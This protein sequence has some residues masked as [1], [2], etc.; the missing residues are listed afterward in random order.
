MRAGLKSIAIGVMSGALALAATMPGFASERCAIPEREFIRPNADDAAR[1]LD[2]F[3]ARMEGMAAA[4]IVESA[5]DRQLVSDLLGSGF[6]AMDADKIPLGSYQCR[7]IK[8][9]GISDLI[10]YSWF[11]CEIGNE[12]NTI[13][14]RKVTGSQNFM[15]FMVPSGESLF[16]RG[17]SHYGYEDGPRFYGDDPEH[18]QVGCFS[19]IDLKAGHFVLELPRPQFESVYDLIEF[20]K[21]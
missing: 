14:V 4:M 5:G 10:I 11:T 8:M 21:N 9:G 20:R 17:A 15:G 6:Q 13:T 7:T 18:D 1:I 12:E 19:A 3:D 16:Y 2:L